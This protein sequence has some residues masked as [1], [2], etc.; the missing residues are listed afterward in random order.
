MVDPIE[1]VEVVEFEVRLE[2]YV[3]KR[4]DA[5]NI[6]IRK[7]KV[8]KDGKDK[9]KEFEDTDSSTFHK[10]V[11]DAAKKLRDML[12][13]RKDIKKLDDIIKAQKASDKTIKEFL[14]NNAI[15]SD[16]SAKHG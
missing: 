10:T 12:V 6:V 3:M 14:Q 8:R 16:K 7:I 4:L 13:E 11:G 2:D 1:D 9:G 5:Y 15:L